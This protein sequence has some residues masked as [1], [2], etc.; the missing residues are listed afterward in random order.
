[1]TSLARTGR[2][3]PSLI[4]AA[5][6]GDENALVLLISAAPPDIRRYAA[7]NCRAADIDDA[8]QETLLLLYRRVG[9]LRAVTSF[10]AWLLA[11]A[12]R[13]CLRLLRG[14]MGMAATPADVAEA[15]LVHLPAEDIRIDLSR[16]IQSLPDHYR[17]VLRDIEELSIDEIGAVLAL[18]RESVKARIH[19]ARLMIREYLVKD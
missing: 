8:V 18:T 10:S 11:V 16:A 19:R 7:R 4:E 15:R 1:M 5:R 14:S 6:C 2:A 9:T 3:D 17:E 12:R 13:A